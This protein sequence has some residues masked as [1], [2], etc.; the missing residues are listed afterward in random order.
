MAARKPLGA[1]QYALLVEALGMVTLASALVAFVPFRRLSRLVAHVPGE[2]TEIE[3]RK[4]IERV[5]WAIGAVARR[6]PYRA[7]CIEQA[8][9]AQ[10]MLTRRGVPAVIHYGVATREG[11]LAAHAWV[12]SGE[13]GVVGCDVAGDYTELAQ[14]PA[15]RETPV[16]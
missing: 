13:I 10:W 15:S 16:R 4:K 11:A 6:V 8:F 2:P 7:M 12:I 9:A 5:R 14:F 3:Q 1:G